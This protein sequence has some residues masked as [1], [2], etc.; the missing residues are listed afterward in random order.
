MKGF[1]SIDLA[2]G[3]VKYAA[4]HFSANPRCPPSWVDKMKSQVPHG[5]WLR[6][7]ELD[8][9]VWAGKPVFQNFADIRH[10]PRHPVCGFF[11][12]KGKPI[13]QYL[14]PNST[15]IAGVDCGSTLHP[16]MTLIEISPQFE[17]ILCVAEYDPFPLP[18]SMNEFAPRVLEFVR[19][20]MPRNY[21]DIEWYSDATANQRAGT[22]KRTA[23][24]VALEHGIDMLPL[25]NVWEP[26]RECID[27]ALMDDI[28]PLVPRLLVD[29]ARC[30]HLLIGF[31]GAYQWDENPD[32]PDFGV[33]RPKKDR[34]SNNLDSLGYAILEAKRRIVGSTLRRSQHRRKR[35]R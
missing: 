15:Y 29:A 20:L 31:Q 27:W 17:Q 10:C 16:A 19:Q 35:G 23:R 5:D 25:S 26:R 30:P 7:Y 34:W 28:E 1:A 8:D 2:G 11:D 32:R 24:M 14:T 3:A 33:K 13:P 22:D 4:L 9:T 18:M 6:E 12:A 21:Q